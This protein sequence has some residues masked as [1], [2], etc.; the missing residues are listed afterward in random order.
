M[1]NQLKRI[2][3]VVCVSIAVAAGM[4]VALAGTGA[5]PG[6]DDANDAMWKRAQRISPGARL[7][8]TMGGESVERYFVQLNA[9]ELVVLN[10]SAPNLPKQ[11]LRNMATEHPA[12]IADTTKTTFRDND[13]RIG[14][15]GLFVKDKKLAELAQVVERIPRDRV[16]VIAKS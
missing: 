8:V 4:N 7:K 5:I 6:A 2:G 15:D 14:P 3:L 13:L 12:W 9:T 11:R 1:R 16:T 10:L